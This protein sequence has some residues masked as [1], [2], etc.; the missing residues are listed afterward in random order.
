MIANITFLGTDYTFDTFGPNDHVSRILLSG[1]MYEP[2]LLGWVGSLG[3]KPGSIAIDAGAYL[4]THSC[5]FMKHLGLKAYAFEPNRRSKDKAKVNLDAANP[6]VKGSSQKLYRLFYGALSVQGGKFSL[7]FPEN[8]AGRS[9]LNYGNTELVPDP[10][11]SVH[12]WGA[13]ALFEEIPQHSKVGF[14]KI[15]CEGMSIEALRALMP[16]INKFKPPLSIEGSRDEIDQ[17]LYPAGYEWEGQFCATPTQGYV[18]RLWQR[19][20]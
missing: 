18:H 10:N 16:I 1:K 9:R 7:R 6:P 11:G 17:L 5:F 12:S 20:S 3:V 8:A 4:G 2:D 15:D 19:G 14:I 13:K